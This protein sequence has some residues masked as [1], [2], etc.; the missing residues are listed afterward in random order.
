MCVVAGSEVVSILEASP[1]E[2]CQTFHDSLVHRGFLGLG[3]KETLE[4]SAHARRF[5]AVAQ[6]E[7]IYRKVGGAA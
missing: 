4:F 3:S 1:R 5:E 6:R 7:R 2:G